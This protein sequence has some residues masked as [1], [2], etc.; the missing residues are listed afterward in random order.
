M[1]NRLTH[2]LGAL[3]RKIE[4]QERAMED[5]R[6]AVNRLQEIVTTVRNER[7]GNLY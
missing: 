7:T 1:T 5:L 3:E 2:R 6:T 4:L